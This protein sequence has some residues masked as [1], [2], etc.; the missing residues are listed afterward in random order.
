[1]RRHGGEKAH[2]LHLASERARAI[3]ARA[4]VA[5]G[6]PEVGT[7]EAR[8]LLWIGRTTRAN[9]VDA[10][11]RRERAREVAA[12]QPR[13][14][15]VRVRERVARQRARRFLARARGRFGKAEVEQRLAAIRERARAA[16]EP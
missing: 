5:S 9:G 6:P 2:R 1:M 7:D 11:V 14:G 13:D 3:R 12:Q 16:V 8:E 4:R 10:L 15:E